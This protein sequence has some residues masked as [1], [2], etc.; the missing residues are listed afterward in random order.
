V[1]Q[2]SKTPVTLVTFWLP[3]GYFGYQEIMV[4]L[5]TKN[6]KN[7]IFILLHYYGTILLA[8][9]YFAFVLITRNKQQSL[10]F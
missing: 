2:I 3:K 7:N 6:N 9:V 8:I 5:V 4:T 10:F 1:G